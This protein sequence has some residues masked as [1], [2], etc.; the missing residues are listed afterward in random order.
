MNFAEECYAEC[1]VCG[2]NSNHYR[3]V[4]GYE[5]V[6]IL[7]GIGTRNVDERSYKIGAA[8]DALSGMVNSDVLLFFYTI[9]VCN[10]A[11]L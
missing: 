10:R 2:D 9:H 1:E 7:G 11:Q 6:K 5:G 3:T 8:T 4:P